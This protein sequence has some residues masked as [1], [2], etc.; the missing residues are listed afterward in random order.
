VFINTKQ[1]KRPPITKKEKGKV[2]VCSTEDQWSERSWFDG[3]NYKICLWTMISVV[4]RS[5]WDLFRSFWIILDIFSTSYTT[6]TSIRTSPCVPSKVGNLFPQ[7]L[8]NPPVECIHRC[9]SPFWQCL[10]LLAAGAMIGNSV[11]SEWPLWRT[12]MVRLDVKTPD[13]KGCRIWFMV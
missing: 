9:T 2:S 4:F 6:Y 12:V 7:R 8:T 3:S 5:F 1:W 10:W 11:A 13:V